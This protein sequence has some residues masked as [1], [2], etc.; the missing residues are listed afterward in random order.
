V[1]NLREMRGSSAGWSRTCNKKNTVDRRVALSSASRWLQH[2]VVGIGYSVYCLVQDRRNLGKPPRPSPRTWFDDAPEWAL[3]V[4]VAVVL[5]LALLYVLI[6]IVKR[7]WE[8][9]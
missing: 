9:A 4:I 7:M 3:G 5:G 8:M 6:W 1:R 2:F